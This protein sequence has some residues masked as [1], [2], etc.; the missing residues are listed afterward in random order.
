MFEELKKGNL[1]RECFEERCSKEEAR[2]VFEDNVKTEQFWNKYFDGDQCEPNPC[3]Y[4]GTCT[5]GIGKFTCMCLDGYHGLQCESVIQ[6]YCKL[7]NGGCRHFCTLVENTVVCSCADGYIL[8]EDETSC[9]ATGSFP[10]GQITVKKGA[11]KKKREASSFGDTIDVF[12]DYDEKDLIF[13]DSLSGQ[14][15]TSDQNFIAQSPSLHS[16]GEVSLSTAQNN[17]NSKT[18][19]EP[20]VRVVGGHDCMPGECPWQALLI[21]EEGTGFCGGTVLNQFFVLTA[22]HCINQT[23]SIRVILGEV[24]T[25]AS[26]RTGTVYTVEKILVH[27]RFVLQ[28]YDYDIAL[29]K[30]KRPIQFS[31]NVTAACLPTPDFANQILMAQD[32]GIVS[33]FGRIHEKGRP[34]E[35]LQVVK[36]P[37]VDR[38][39]CKLS[40]NF[41]ITENMFCAGYDT[42]AQDACQGDSGGPHVT[43]YKGTYFVTGIVSWGE[44]CAR[45]GKY[46]VYTKVSKF[47]FW[48]KRTMARNMQNNVA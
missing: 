44:G 17:S 33:G 27:Q 41:A 46:G 11:P 15:F 31:V 34:S 30:L 12:H 3:H 13:D 2:E 1:E 21:N 36:L 40:S 19:D 42:A 14:N 37:Y 22:A 5:D 24:D 32:A 9:V 25:A 35:K 39:T 7:N 45:K 8:G 47:I 28:T 16:Q 29:I 23:K 6:K 43:E 26:E 20:D 4:G 48:I 10:C 38:N 18:E